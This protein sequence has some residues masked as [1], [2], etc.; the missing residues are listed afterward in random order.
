MDFRAAPVDWNARMRAAAAA[1]FRRPER[2]FPVLISKEEGILS[3]PEQLKKLADIPETPKIIK[4]TW[5]TLL[6]SMDPANRI[7]GEKAEV[8][9]VAEPDCVTWHRRAEIEDDI[10]RLVWIGDTPRVALVVAAI[11]KSMTPTKT[12]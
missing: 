9:V 4:T 12:T 2:Y 6:G 10:D 3:S 1:G 11:K 5:T 7:S 8:C